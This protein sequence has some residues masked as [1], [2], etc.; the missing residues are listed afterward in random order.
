MVVFDIVQ[1]GACNLFQCIQRPKSSKKF[2]CKVCRAKNSIR[3]VYASSEKNREIRP[4][5]QQLNSRNLSKGE[6]QAGEREHEPPFA[7]ASRIRESSVVN[8]LN[9][10]RIKRCRTDTNEGF[11][12]EFSF[13]MG[14]RVAMEQPGRDIEQHHYDT[15]HYNSDTEQYHYDT[16]QLGSCQASLGANGEGDWYADQNSIANAKYEIRSNLQHEFPEEP[17]S[18]WDEFA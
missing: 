7:T 4:I 16:E 18:E 8:D 5:C 15:E 3:K 13:R 1:C 17:K 10:T 2:I 11:P 14:H 6:A 9:P 12:T